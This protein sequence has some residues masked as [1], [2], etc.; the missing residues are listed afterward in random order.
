MNTI[1]VKNLSTLPNSAVLLR[2][3][4]FIAGKHEEALTDLNGRKQ[5]DIVEEENMTYVITDYEGVSFF[6]EVKN[7]RQA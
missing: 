7:C 3:G 1:T 4:M 2:V 6:E 5:I